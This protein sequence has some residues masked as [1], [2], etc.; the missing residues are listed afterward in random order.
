MNFHLAWWLWAKIF[1]IYESLHWLKTYAIDRCYGGGSLRLPPWKLCFYGAKL[2]LNICIKMILIILS[3]SDAVWLLFYSYVDYILQHILPFV[4]MIMQVLNTD[5][6]EDLQLLVVISRPPVKVWAVI[7]ISLLTICNH[8]SL[9]HIL[10][11]KYLMQDFIRY[12]YIF[13]STISFS[14]SFPFL[15][16]LK[17][18]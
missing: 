2:R 3:N 1:I 18:P 11:E 12:C 4:F 9:N 7:L 8:F 5:E 14:F 10:I 15:H 17:K 16:H 6:H 13:I